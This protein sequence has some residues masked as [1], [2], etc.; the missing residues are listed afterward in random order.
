MDSEGI[1]MDMWKTLI[2]LQNIGLIT[3]VYWY[4]FEHG[5]QSS[6]PP[7]L[8]PLPSFG[9]DVEVTKSVRNWVW[10]NPK[11]DGPLVPRGM[12]VMCCEVQ[13]RF[14]Y[15][16]EIQRRADSEEMFRGLVFSLGPDADLDP[17][18]D[19]LLSGIRH[20]EGVFPKLA[21]LMASCSGQAEVFKHSE[22]RKDRVPC[23]A[24][25]RNALSKLDLFL[26]E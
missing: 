15:I 22:S 19:D 13:E 11:D 4:T 8:I 10:M 24:A 1:L 5:Y 7:K 23:E 16:V 9:R 3:S 6:S 12:L 26:S 14:V 21:N 25:V 17:W 20:V 2:Y 18:L